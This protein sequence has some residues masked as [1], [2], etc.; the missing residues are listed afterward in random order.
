[1]VYE[2]LYTRSENSD[3]SL[4]AAVSPILCL[5]TS[6]SLS[7]VKLLSMLLSLTK[8]GINLSFHFVQSNEIVYL[9]LDTLHC[10]PVA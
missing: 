2:D 6:E 4:L 3:C 8:C 7:S 5:P 10:R 1:M 9:R